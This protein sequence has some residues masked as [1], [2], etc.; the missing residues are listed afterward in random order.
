[1]VEILTETEIKEVINS[2][3]IVPKQALLLIRQFI[4][5]KKGEVVEGIEE[6]NNTHH[7]TLMRVAFDKAKEYYLDKFKE[8]EKTD[9]EEKSSSL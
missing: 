7:F 2:T 8:V 5:D 4:Y 6:P 1:M 9:G 3:Q